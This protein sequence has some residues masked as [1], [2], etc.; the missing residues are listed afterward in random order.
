MDVREVLLC[1]RKGD[2]LV[3]HPSA[4]VSGRMVLPCR[5]AEQLAL[6][7]VPVELLLPHPSTAGHGS[8]SFPSCHPSLPLPPNTFSQTVNLNQVWQRQEFSMKLVQIWGEF[9]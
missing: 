4:Q 2:P 3:A 5:A 8:L 9:G 1:C 6:L 7:P